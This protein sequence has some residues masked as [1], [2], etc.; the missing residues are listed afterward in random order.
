MPLEGT[1]LGKS[2]EATQAILFLCKAL[3]DKRGMR[4]AAGTYL[5]VRL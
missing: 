3:G 4:R 2:T 5:Y 1:L